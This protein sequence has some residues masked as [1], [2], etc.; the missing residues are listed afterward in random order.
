[1]TVMTDGSAIEVATIGKEGMVGLI[2]FVG[3]ETSP[4]EV[5]VQVVAYGFR[6]PVEAFKEEAARNSHLRDVLGAL[7]HGLLG[8]GFVFGGV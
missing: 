4:N 8:S 2:A 5:M 6:M 7:Q 1:M 3:D